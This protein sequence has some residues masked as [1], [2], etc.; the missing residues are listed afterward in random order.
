MDDQDNQPVKDPKAS[1][2]V[3]DMADTVDCTGM[4]IL[5]SIAAWAGGHLGTGVA[6]FCALR[7]IGL[8]IDQKRS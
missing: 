2:T 1:P 3:G 7:F 4:L 5:A 6:V 8:K